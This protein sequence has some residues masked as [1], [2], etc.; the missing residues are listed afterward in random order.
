[1]TLITVRHGQR[2]ALLLPK[3]AGGFVWRGAL[4]THVRVAAPL[5]EGEVSGDIVLVYTALRAGRTTIA[6]ALTRGETTRAYRSQ[7]FVVTVV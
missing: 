4:N 1:V 6:Y 5:N 2:F 7:T 3:P